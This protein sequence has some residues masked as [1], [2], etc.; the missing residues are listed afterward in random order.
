MLTQRLAAK[1]PPSSVLAAAAKKYLLAALKN[2]SW[3]FAQRQRLV[4]RLGEIAAHLEAHPPR[5]HRGSP[6]SAVLQPDGPPLVPKLSRGRVGRRA[7]RGVQ[8][9]LRVVLA[10][11]G[12]N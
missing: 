12:D 2:P 4:D 5:T 9:Q 7:P 10:G 11:E 8:P 6:F 3:S 1:V